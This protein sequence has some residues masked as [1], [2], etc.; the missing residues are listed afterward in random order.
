LAAL[1][2]EVEPGVFVA[3]GPPKVGET[4]IDMVKKMRRYV[5]PPSMD[6]V[7]YNQIQPFAMYVF[8]FKHNLSKKDLADIWQNLPPDIG[9]SFD[10]A[11][12]SISHELLAHELLGGGSVIK[13]GQLD[14]NAEGNE[15]PSNIQWMIFKVKRRAKTKYKEKVIQNTGRLPKPALQLLTTGLMI[16]FRLLN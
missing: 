16:S 8:E 10:E 7:R 3:G 1:R 11:E 5:F 15:I 2:R 13:D 6:F 14:E 9:T 12:A 4:I